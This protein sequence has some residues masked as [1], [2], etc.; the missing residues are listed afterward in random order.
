MKIEK[1]ISQCRRDYSAL[2]KCEFCGHTST[3]NSGYINRNYQ[4]NVIPNM[5]CGK[6]GESTTSKK[7]KVDKTQL[8]IQKNFKFKRI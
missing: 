5:K 7:D 2:M 8:N 1:I 4:S 3:D 6:C